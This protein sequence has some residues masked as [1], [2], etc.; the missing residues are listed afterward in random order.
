MESLYSS[1]YASKAIECSSNILLKTK[2]FKKAI[3][4]Q[5]AFCRSSRKALGFPS[6]IKGGLNLKIEQFATRQRLAICD[7]G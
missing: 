6:L 7:E 5:E 4:I 3:R 2:A 1:N